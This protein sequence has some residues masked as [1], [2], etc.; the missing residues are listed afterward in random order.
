MITSNQTM[1]EWMRWLSRS[2]TVLV[3]AFAATPLLAAPARAC[4]C[5]MPPDI[6]AWVDESEAAFVGTL[7]EKRDAGMGD[8]GAESIYVFEVE[9]WV[10]GNAGEVIEVRSSS[11]GASCGFEFWDPDQRIGA[12]LREEGGELH[13]GLCDQV[14][15]DVLLAALTPPTPSS[16]GI[17]HLLIGGGWLSAHL[18]VVDEVGH[19]V[20]DLDPPDVDPTGASTMLDLC[21]GGRLVAQ[22]T[23]GTVVVW[24]LTTYEA[25][26][27]HPVLG[28]W[29]ADVSCQAED[30]SSIWV[31]AGDEVTGVLTEV[32]GEHEV[33]HELPGPTGVIGT[34]FVVVQ[35]T[36]E[37]DAIWFDPETGETTEL[38][39]TPPDELRSVSVATHPG[40]QLVAV[41]ETR[42]A[43]NAAPTATLT[44]FDATGTAVKT[45]DLP[46]ESYT[47]VWLDDNRMMVNSYGE[48]LGDGISLIY[49]IDTGETLEIEGWAMEHTIIDGDT[50]YGVRGGSVMTTSLNNPEIGTLVALPT[51]GSGPLI[52][53]EDAPAIEVGTTTIPTETEDT[54]P[55]L[56][57]AGEPD[58]GTGYIP[59]VAGGVMVVFFGTLIWLSRR[60]RDK[61]AADG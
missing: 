44:I 43:E 27:S 61:S 24:D 31:L 46:G 18:T 7:L 36:H 35:E 29:V 19:H 6:A 1:S 25:V 54:T 38:T 11:D 28:G 33:L 26:A 16:T 30:A 48:N 58:S 52:L 53:L 21:P 12:V 57:A 17:G 8:F 13:G 50:L 41:V 9:Q 49:D 59:W 60:P 10:K 47:P 20:I 40:E 4:S 32:V 51:Q 3:V 14:E 34:G 5:A 39:S 42:F 56:I 2:M 55:P 45:F 23:P 15:P 37:G 22:A